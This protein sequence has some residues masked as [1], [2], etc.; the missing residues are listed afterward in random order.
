MA[1]RDATDH[2]YVLADF[3]PPSNG[4][5]HHEDDGAL[6]FRADAEPPLEKFIALAQLEKRFKQTWERNRTDLTDRSPSGWDMALANQVIEVGWTDQEIVNLLIAHR[7]KHGDDLKLGREDY[8]RATIRTARVQ[9]GDLTVLTFGTAESEDGR[10]ARLEFLR[11]HFQMPIGGLLRHPGPPDSYVLLT[12]QGGMSIKNAEIL[13]SANKM[14]ALWLQHTGRVLPPFKPLLWT[15]I[16][17]ALADIQTDDVLAEQ[18]EAGRVQSWIDD[19]LDS[20]TVWDT[21]EMAL[22]Y[23]NPFYEARRGGRLCLFLSNFHGW[24]LLQRHEQITSRELAALL[25]KQNWEPATLG[26]RIAKSDKSYTTR[27][28]WMT[29]YDRQS[30]IT[31]AD[32]QGGSPPTG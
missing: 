28:V 30:R 4:T 27:S 31:S 10:A 19:Y 7:R 3:I 13:L 8:Y 23:R 14:R 5:A 32:D 6:V 11:E 21:I 26:V 12:D 18:T 9:R 17:Q 29:P 24:L 2:V 15:A 25:R 20:E 1:E 22:P 16:V